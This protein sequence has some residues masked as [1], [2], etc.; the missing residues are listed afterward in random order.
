M[1]LKFKIKD[2]LKREFN[3]EKRLESPQNWLQNS[4]FDECVKSGKEVEILTISGKKIT[5]VIQAYDN[6]SFFV[7]TQEGEFLE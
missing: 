3:E 2:T 1:T 6:Y 4:F 5:G 7:E